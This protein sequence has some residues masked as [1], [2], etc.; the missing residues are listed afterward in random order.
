V[1]K[2]QH[3]RII[4]Y[5]YCGAEYEDLEKCPNCDLDRFNC[6]K[7]IGDDEN[8]NRRNDGPKKVF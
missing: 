6:R 8:C 1:E 3:A 4:A 2:I 7:H 5:I